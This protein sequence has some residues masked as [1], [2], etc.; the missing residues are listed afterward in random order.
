LDAFETLW[1]LAVALYCTF[2]TPV[3]LPSLHLKP[4]SSVAADLV[5]LALDRDFD[6]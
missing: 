4:G 3:R 1:H 5:L 6:Y 2:G